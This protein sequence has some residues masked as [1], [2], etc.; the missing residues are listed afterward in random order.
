M[1]IKYSVA[2]ENGVYLFGQLK[3]EGA[4]QAS[5]GVVVALHPRTGKLL[6]KYNDRGLRGQ[7]NY[8]M[9][10]KGRC[11]YAAGEG[12]AFAFDSGSGELLWRTRWNRRKHRPSGVVVSQGQ[13]YVV[14]SD[15]T[16]MGLR[17]KDGKQSWKTTVDLYGVPIALACGEKLVIFADGDESFLAIRAA[18]GK[19]V[20][21]GK[22]PRVNR[23]GD[24]LPFAPSA[25]P[26]LAGNAILIPTWAGLQHDGAYLAAISLDDGQVKWKTVLRGQ[27]GGGVATDGRRACVPMDTSISKE[28]YHT[29]SGGLVCVNLRDGNVVWENLGLGS[30]AYAPIISDKTVLAVTPAGNLVALGMDRGGLLWLIGLG[31]RMSPGEGRVLVFGDL[32]IVTNR[33]RI[34]V[35]E[36]SQLED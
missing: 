33:S 1:S 30:V 24:M 2:C 31:S 36:L 16:V 23:G 28:K 7:Q 35:F 27:G 12:G 5:D 19:P 8:C 4:S 29:V 32:L 25:I 6:W 18:D 17:E 11:L 21:G 22:L 15:G 26:T 10:L 13:V 20:W 9:V 3:A 34:W 14:F